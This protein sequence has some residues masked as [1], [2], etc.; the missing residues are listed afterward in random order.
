VV[1]DIFDQRLVLSRLF[2]ERLDFFLKVSLG[3]G[4]SRATKKER[5]SIGRQRTFAPISEKE[6]LLEVL[7]SI[8]KLVANDM[9]NAGMKAKKLTLAMKSAD[10]V[11]KNRAK[12]LSHFISSESELYMAASEVLLSVLPVNLRLIGIRM[13]CFDIIQK[14]QE[15]DTTQKS[16]YTYFSKVEGDSLAR[17]SDTKLQT[18]S[19]NKSK[20]LQPLS[21][22]QSSPQK[23]K[24]TITTE[25]T[26]HT[27]KTKGNIQKDSPLKR[28]PST[29]KESNP[30]KG[31]ISFFFIT[32]TWKNI[33]NYHFCY[34]TT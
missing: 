27:E 34:G 21:M 24:T 14:Q 12:T 4:E 5:K 8:A 25:T 20:K 18:N 22:W 13:S 10:F 28:R 6:K 2:P 16:I 30:K 7:K 32:L 31:V 33:T 15:V 26:T 3:L 9:S 17:D 19:P 11:V 29:N 23:S 1:Q